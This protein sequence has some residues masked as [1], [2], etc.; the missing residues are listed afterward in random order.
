M[1]LMEK[2]FHYEM[3]TVCKGL[4]SKHRQQQTTYNHVGCQLYDLHPNSDLCIF[5][6]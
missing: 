4:V 6:N 3:Y 2:K 5:K 1:V